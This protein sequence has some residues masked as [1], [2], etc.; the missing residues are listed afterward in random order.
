MDGSDIGDTQG[1]PKGCLLVLVGGFGGAIMRSGGGRN[2]N[3]AGSESS[4]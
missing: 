4:C 1:W 2:D 3:D